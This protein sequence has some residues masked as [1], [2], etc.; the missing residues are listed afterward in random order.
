MSKAYPMT[1]RLANRIVSMVEEELNEYSSDNVDVVLNE[2]T[3]KLD[4]MY[5]S[6]NNSFLIRATDID[7]DKVD[8]E[9]LEEGLDEFSVG[10][11]W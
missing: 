9:I 8:L 4:I 7:A 2:E 3:G 1:E 5:H 11:V 6:D 10:H